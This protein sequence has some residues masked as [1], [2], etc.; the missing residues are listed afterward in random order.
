MDGEKLETV[1]RAANNLIDRLGKND[2]AAIISFNFETSVDQP[3]TYDKEALRASVNALR[4]SFSTKYG[5]ALRAAERA[6]TDDA[7]DKALIFLSDGKSDFS[8]TPRELE[9]LTRALAENDVCILTI[10]YALGGDESEQLSMMAKVGRERGCGEH[11]IA[12]EK[13]T[14]L[15][16]VFTNIRDRLSSTIVLNLEPT[17]N[18]GRYSFRFSSALNNFTVPGTSGSVCAEYPSFDMAVYNANNRIVYTTTLS[19]GTVPLEQGVYTYHARA[20]L[21]CG[22]ACAFSGEDEGTFTISGACNPTYPELASYVTG[23]TQTV[24]ITPSGFSPR[25]IAARQGTPVIWNNTDIVPRRLTSAHFNTTIPPGGQFTYIIDNVG[26]LIFVDPD[27]KQELSIST[28]SAGGSDVMLIIDESGSMKGAPI[29]EARAAAQDFFQTL[30]P[31][32]RGGL[33]T[34]SQTATLVQEYTNDRKALIDAAGKLRS[35]AATSYLAALRLAALQRPQQ[36]SIL[37]FMSDGIPTDEE[38]IDTILAET[39]ALRERG[40]CIMTVGFGEGGE[41]AQSVLTRMAGEDSCS[42]FLY[43]SSGELTKTF[44]SVYQLALRGNDLRFALHNAKKITFVPTV[45]V[46]T[47]IET[48]TGQPVPGGVSACAPPASVQVRVRGSATT[49]EYDGNNFYEGTLSVPPGRSRMQFSASVYSTDEPSRP[50]VGTYDTT[51]L[52]IPLWLLATLIV[53]IGALI[54]MW[55]TKEP[56]KPPVQSAQPQEEK[57]V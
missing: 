4:A 9:E 46:T 13:G 42:G 37:V 18:E 56:A 47:R 52:Y 16:E 28:I 40:W 22:G 31:A 54:G 43:A 36:R 19:N 35:E 29:A 44:G 21:S 50:L 23:D 7:H 2:R 26:T 6:Y 49:L 34:F 10:S 38:G 1:K 3:L 11:Y 24:R 20:T 51:I 45:H 14:E 39:A 27:T 41:Q 55:L 5:P 12:S 30:S 32:D 53:L 15:E 33:I 48:K 8:E 25:S 57:L 17:F